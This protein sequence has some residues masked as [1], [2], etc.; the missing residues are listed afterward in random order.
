MKTTKFQRITALI[1]LVMIVF[2]GS[3]LPVSAANDENEESSLERIKALLNAI[4]YDEYRREYTSDEELKKLSDGDDATNPKYFDL[5]PSAESEIVLNGLDG[6]YVNSLGDVLTYD[7]ATVIK[8]GDEIPKAETPYKF[9]DGTTDGLYVPDVGTTT[10]TI[11]ADDENAI[12]APTRYNIY[13]EYFPIENKSAS[14]ERVFM[15]ND[16]VPF[17]EARYL[18]ISKVWATPYPDGQIE[19]ARGETAQEIIDAAKAA[20]FREAK[21]AVNTRGETIVAVSFPEYW[22]TELAQFVQDY[23]VRYFMSDTDKNEIRESLVQA[24]EWTTYHFKDSSGFLQEPFDFVVEPDENGDVT[25]TLEG[26]NEPIVISKLCLTPCVEYESYSSYHER[27]ANNGKGEGTLKIEAEYFSA[28]SSQTIYPISDTTSAANSPSATD[29]TLLNAVGGGKWQTVGQWIEYNFTVPKSGNYNIVAR[30]KQN[31]LDGMATSRVL[32]LYSDE[33][34]KEGDDGYYNGVPFD[35]ATRLKFNYSDD[36]QVGPLSDGTTDFEF[37]FKEGVTYTVRFEVSLGAMGS[38]V[39]RVQTVLDAI[40]KDYLDIL[41][42]TGTSPDEF[43]TY[44]FYGVIPGT[45][46]DMVQQH[47]EIEE[48]IAIMLE[49]S[50]KSSM[51]AT[52]QNVSDLLIEMS[53]GGDEEV[54]KNLSQLKTYIGSLGTWLGDAKTQPLALD[55]IVI[56]NSDEE[57]PKA[58]ANFFEALWHEITGFI[59][60]FFRNYDRMG[61]LTDEVA[62]DSV[63]VWIATGRDQSQVIRN[64]I[65]NKFTKEHGVTV[66]LRLVAGGTLLPSILAKKGPDVYLGIGAG[67]VINYAIRGALESIEEMDGFEEA[68]ASFNESAMIVLQMEDAY[69]KNRCYGLPETQGFPMMFVR[70]DILAELEIEVPKTWDDVKE[71]IPVLQ[72]NNME[73]AMIGDSNIFIYQM[74]GELFADGGMRINLD[75]NLALTAFEDMCSMY[76]MYSFPYQYDFA[77]R[78][79]TGEMPIGFGDYTG[80]Y[81]HLKVFAT[82]IEGLW[83]FYPLPGIEDANGNVRFDSVSGVGAIAMIVDCESKERSWTFMKW[84]VGDECQV[85]YSNEMAAILGPSAKHA[86]AN[87]TALESLPWTRAE[88]EQIKLQFDNLASIPNYP[89]AYIVGRYTKFAFL[90]AYNDNLNPVS[91]LKGYI[92]DINEEITRKRDE[93]DL[94]SLDADEKQTT[95]A[96]RRMQQAETALEKAKEDS[97]YSAAYDEKVDEI[98]REIANYSTE[99]FDRLSALADDL[100]ALD[101]DLFGTGNKADDLDVDAELE[102]DKIYKAVYYLKD[103]AKWLKTYEAYKYLG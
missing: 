86:T 88:Y 64:L 82:E 77:N 84:Y 32:E 99:D 27:Y 103:A 70:E 21:E 19:I 39:S 6:V 65:N 89:G 52:L 43:A 20:G 74:G 79:R 31:V 23:T 56:Q 71:A 72:A 1:L 78:F 29:R 94:E 57:L 26:V 28:S 25:F 76:T 83:S 61:A 73:I 60:S 46:S 2:G 49:D 100:A 101:S 62:E 15:I 68:T 59:Q 24:P 40:N 16:E 87:I 80:T 42:L 66:N 44:N 58:K 96:I 53:S 93:F 67:D 9:T 63:E 11:K 95:L 90:D 18:T 54:A 35:E 8:P 3:V 12:T 92:D 48:I 10:W 91:S 33:T 13:V 22:N 45:M 102:K 34:L 7:E 55:Y 17:S 81:N 5:V 51:T 47:K 85:D 36:W 30:F 69:G 14:I 41:K 4:S 38:T 75:S 50:S 98:L 37:Y 97:R